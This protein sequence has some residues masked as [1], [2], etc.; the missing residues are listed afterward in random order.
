M[1]PVGDG[2]SHTRS[3]S[4]F[5]VSAEA[6]GN[7]ILDSFARFPF[8]RRVV[9]E[10]RRVR[11]KRKADEQQWEQ[12]KAKLGAGK[13]RRDLCLP[14]DLASLTAIDHSRLIR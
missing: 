14:V 9:S 11:A 10:D 3:A 13:D 4:K 6:A 2:T 12:L 7:V 5:S 8:L 1:V